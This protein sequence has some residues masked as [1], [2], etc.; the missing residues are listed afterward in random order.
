MV[1]LLKRKNEGFFWAL[2]FCWLYG[3]FLGCYSCGFGFAK[4]MRDFFFFFDAFG[5][6]FGLKKG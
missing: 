2:G 5:S 6:I 1:F 3:G 4:E